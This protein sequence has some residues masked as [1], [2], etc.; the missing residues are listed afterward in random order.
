MIFILCML[1]PLRKIQYHFFLL[2]S[3]SYAVSYIS[4]PNLELTRLK[5]TSLEAMA[6]KPGTQIII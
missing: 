3:F 1:K 5:R 6:M 2:K 4:V